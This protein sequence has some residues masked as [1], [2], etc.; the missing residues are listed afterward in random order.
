M[1]LQNWK[2]Q[3]KSMNK[4]STEREWEKHE[5]LPVACGAQRED[6][7]DWLGAALAL[8]AGLVIEVIGSRCC[9]LEHYHPNCLSQTPVRHLGSQIEVMVWG[10]LLA[11]HRTVQTLKFSHCFR[12]LW[13]MIEG[14]SMRQIH[15]LNDKTSTGHAIFLVTLCRPGFFGWPTYCSIY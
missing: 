4:I 14:F 10:L 8:N 12:K 1:Q 5:G 9:Q 7:A 15:M 13:R 6:P 2:P 3:S 11:L